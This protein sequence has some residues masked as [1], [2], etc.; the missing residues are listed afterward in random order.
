MQTF[1]PSMVIEDSYERPIAV[2]EVTSLSDM[3]LDDALEIRE[4]TLGRGLPAHVPY[5]LLVSQDIGFLWKNNPS[6]NVNSSPDYEFPMHNVMVRF[7]RKLPEQRLYAEELGYVVLRW[8]MNLS[9]RSQDMGQEPEKTLAR[10]G[11]V[12]AIKGAKE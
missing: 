12:D 7:S 10:A 2:V 6:L 4:S 1:Q 5:F 9:S 11:F 8:L 3:I